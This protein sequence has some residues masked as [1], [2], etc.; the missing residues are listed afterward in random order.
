MILLFFLWFF[1]WHYNSKDF[2]KM[3]ITWNR[4][5]RKMNSLPYGTLL[6]PLTNQRHIRYQ[7][8]ARYISVTFY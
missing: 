5:V 7:L 3:C 6:G 2:E 8:F 4:A 1:L